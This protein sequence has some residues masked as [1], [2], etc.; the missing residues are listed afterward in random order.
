MD[1][2]AWTS[3]KDKLKK[4]FGP[5]SN[6]P[7]DV[8]SI[9]QNLKDLQQHFDE[10]QKKIAFTY[11]ILNEQ[12]DR[13]VGCLYL[14]RS[15][16]PFFDCRIDFWFTK[17]FDHS[18][19]VDFMKNI[20]IWL[21][22]CWKLEKL[23]FP[24]RNISWR[25]W[26]ALSSGSLFNLRPAELDFWKSYIESLSEENLPIEPNIFATVPGGEEKADDLLQLYLLNKKNA[27]SGLVKYFERENIP[28]PKE[29]DFW[30]VLNSK[31]EPKL[32]NKNINNKIFKFKDVTREIVIAEGEGDLSIE[33]WKK[34]H[35]VFFTYFVEKYQIVDLEEELIVT[36]F[37]EQVYKA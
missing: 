32:I 8:S 26:Y 35:R 9:D 10:H 27:G 16:S 29:G 34:E 11:T 22:D 25:K 36:E 37:F 23:A 4:I 24:G 3:S 20:K 19:D 31:N 33:E 6:W 28:M 1:Y 30:I 21:T 2:E 15:S 18:D 13:C 7:N 12:K 5:K 17:E 14:R